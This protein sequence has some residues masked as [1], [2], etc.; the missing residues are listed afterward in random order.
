MDF[1]GYGNFQ[2]YGEGCIWTEY[3]ER[4][5]Q[6]SAV[7]VVGLGV[8]RLM[9]TGISLMRIV[10]SRQAAAVGVAGQESSSGEPADGDKALQGVGG[11]VAFR[12]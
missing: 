4:G 8:C 7:G 6:H 2:G 3:V 5:D 1:Q 11:A 12:R 10:G 9:E